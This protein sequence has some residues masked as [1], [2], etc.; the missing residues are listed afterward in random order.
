MGLFQLILG[1]SLDFIPDVIYKR[2]RVNHI[3]TEKDLEFQPRYRCYPFALMTALILYLSK[4]DNPTKEKGGKQ[5]TI[6]TY[7]P[8]GVKVIL[9]LL[10]KVV[11]V[12][13]KFPEIQ[14]GKSSLKQLF[15]EPSM[16]WSQV[17]N[18]L[19]KC[20][21]KLFKLFFGG[22]QSWDGSCR[23]RGIKRSGR[24]RWN[25]TIRDGGFIG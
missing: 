24:A 11:A 18:G 1:V 2:L 12:Y 4:A 23:C 17:L 9:T 7:G 5:D 6:I 19:H 15:L 25:F 20:L 22:D 13:M 3:F 8:S 21:H 16:S 14:V 10:T